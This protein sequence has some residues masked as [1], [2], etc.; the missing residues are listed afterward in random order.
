MWVAA[1]LVVMSA[2]KTVSTTVTLSEG[3][4]WAYIS[5]FA[6]DRGTGEFSVRVKFTKPIKSSNS[7]VP[8]SLQ[9]FQD[10][11]WE[12]VLNQETCRAKERMAKQQKHIWV[13]EDGSWSIDIKG[14]MKQKIRPY[15]WYI[16]LGDCDGTLKDSYRIRVQATLTNADG[17]HF[18]L[19]DQGLEY[20]YLFF[21][22]AFMAALSTSV[23][24]LLKRFNQTETL[25]PPLFMLNLAISAEI[26]SL[27]FEG[28]HLIVY[29]YDGSGISLFDFFHQTS[30]LG[31]QLIVT[32]WFLLVSTGWTLKYSDFPDL[33]ILLPVGFL[34]TILNLM[35]AGLGRLT[36]D[37][38]S[39][40]TDYEGIAGILLLLLRLGMWGWFAY[41]MKGLYAG[42]QGTAKTLVW[43]LGL[44]G[45]L[46]LLTLPGL[47]AVSWVIAPYIR[48]K[49]VVI[50]ALGLQL[51][52]FMLLSKLM[53]E[54]SQY[55]KMSTLS[56]SVLPGS[57]S[58]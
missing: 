24:K 3:T 38:Q 23:F 50:G 16:A 10:L 53:G 51:A 17:S 35:I 22:V 39:K 41:N 27:M 29:S 5:K 2:G 34:V 25:E 15:Y 45:S 8:L 12:D 32:V 30:D 56:S 4:N 42:S 58:R 54:K 48:K 26:S 31:S 18:S 28:I 37:S 33:E 52:V 47:V 55:Y 46:Y 40:Y 9:L 44:L 14:I 20:V 13:P 43:N 36:D 57:K 1:F 6:V 49:V 7:T 19:E 21:F 11:T